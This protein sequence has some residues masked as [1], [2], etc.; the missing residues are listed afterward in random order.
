[1]KEVEKETKELVRILSKTFQEEPIKVVDL[2]DS[3]TRITEKK[4]T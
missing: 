2:I 3:Q 1:M 4:K